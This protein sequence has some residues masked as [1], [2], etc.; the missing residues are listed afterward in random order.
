MPVDKA[1]VGALRNLIEETDLILSTTTPLPE[2]RTARC[3]ELLRSALALV[4]DIGAE[5]ESAAAQLGRKG[6]STT[7]SRRGPEYF[8]ELAKK[9]KTHGGGRPA[10]KG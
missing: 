1:S 6:G 4:S 5:S 9:R 3:R 8:R 7:A 2:N 10:N